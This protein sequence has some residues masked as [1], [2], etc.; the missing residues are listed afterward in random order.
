MAASPKSDSSPTRS[1][2]RTGYPEIRSSHLG[3]GEFGS[4]QRGSIEN[5][6]GEVLAGEVPA[7]HVLII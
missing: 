7:A 3:V 6:I 4:R 1:I 2:P 5:R